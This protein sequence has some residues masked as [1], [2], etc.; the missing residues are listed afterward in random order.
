MASAALG[1]V[2]AVAAGV[3]SSLYLLVLG[4]NSVVAVVRGLSPA[5]GELPLWG[6]LALATAAATMVLLTHVPRHERR[7][8]PA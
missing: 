2:L 7:K 5:P 4:G 8:E 1:Y 3:G 6:P